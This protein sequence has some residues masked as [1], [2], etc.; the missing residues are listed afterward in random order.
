MF[1]SRSNDGLAETLWTDDP[2]L[3]R[4]FVLGDDSPM[5]K[6]WTTGAGSDLLDRIPRDRAASEIIRRIEAARPPARGKLEVLR[7]YSW[8]KQP[9][10]RGIYHHIG[11]GQAAALA[12]ATRHESGRLHFAGEH[13]AQSS[14][15][16]ASSGMEGALE[17]GERAARTVLARA[18]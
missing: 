5:L 6:L 18:A 3:G 15:G 10:S 4:I 1:S 11:T 17:S 13:L 8:Q 2:L 12:A 14:S 9:E 16:M 7:F